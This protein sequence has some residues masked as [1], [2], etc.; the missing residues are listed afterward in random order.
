MSATESEERGGRGAQRCWK[1]SMKQLLPN[2]ARHPGGRVAQAARC[3]GPG[4]ATPGALLEPLANRDAERAVGER[5]PHFPASCAPQPLRPSNSVARITRP[6]LPAV[7]S[8]AACIM[9]H[10]NT[11]CAGVCSAYTCASET[12]WSRVS[13][14][15]QRLALLRVTSTWTMKWRSL[16]N[17]HPRRPLQAQAMGANSASS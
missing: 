14:A 13:Q 7:K 9:F 10:L 6:L 17:K 2:S 5:Q 12:A 3:A 15:R 8:R 1:G 11:L 4:P 16:Q